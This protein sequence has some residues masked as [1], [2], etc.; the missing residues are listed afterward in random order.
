MTATNSA[1]AN[2][3][4]RVQVV[5]IGSL[6]MIAILIGLLM[7]PPKTD[8]PGA[9]TTSEPLV[10]Y[11][12]AGIKPPV[13]A[14]TR[15]YERVYGVPLHLQYGGSGTLL[16]NIRVSR[17]GDLFLAGDTGY[18]EEARR[19]GLLAEVIP[20]ARVRA[21]L[22]VRQGNPKGIRALPDLLRDD[23]TVAMANPDAAAIG[24]LTRE[25]LRETGDW[26]ALEKRCKVF[27]PTVNDVANDVMIGSVDAGIVWD[28]TAAQRPELDLVRAAALEAVT[29]EI[30]VGVLT[31]SRR[32]T[33]AL[34]FARYLGARDRGLRTFAQ[35]RYEP[36]EGDAWAETPSITFYSGAMLRPAIEKT[37]R[38][39]EAREGCRIT[40]VYNGC[41]ILVAQ[42]KAGER[43]DAYFACDVAFMRQVADLYA[44][45]T[46]VS[47]NRL[48]ILV[49]KGNPRRMRAVADLAQAGVR[50][51]LA[52]PEKSAM[53]AQT[54]ALL[55][56]LG[57][58]AALAKNLQVDSPTG[59]LLVN[60]MRAGSLDAVIVC[61]SNAAQVREHVETV[62]I[63]HPLA[64]MTQPYAVARQSPHRHLLLRLQERLTDAESRHRFEA[65][66]FDW[67]TGATL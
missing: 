12:A 50:L 62:E 63:E 53:G 57:L 7:W 18:L 44:N 10:F 19:L 31:C 21:V 25:R 59:D 6:V 34:R 41:G 3:A 1:R 51:G 32:P 20:L 16:S 2:G 26:E 24:R 43:P 65:A 27:K 56:A 48:V 22:A 61:R 23:V 28:A 46:N 17:L 49:P 15:E 38:E 66:G 67:H 37:L 45:P 54:K 36:V 47:D 11:C 33:A 35:Y 9:G 4:S 14:V 60:Q 52:H 29:S 13:E 64:G 39:F 42:M 5:A 30:S 40:T 8:T 55:D 58:S